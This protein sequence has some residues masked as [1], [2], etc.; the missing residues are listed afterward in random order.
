[1]I[2]RPPRSTLFPYTTL[3]RSVLAVLD[4]TLVPTG[5]QLRAQKG[6]PLGVDIRLEG[7][8][9]A[10]D[11]RVEEL[12][13]LVAAKPAEAPAEVW[14]AREAL[15]VGAEPAVGCRLSVLPTRLGALCARVGREAEH[16]GRPWR[17]VAPAGRPGWLSAGG[18]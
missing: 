18:G 1:M 14:E 10:L 9:A 8:E 17:V 7:E 5:L 11:A 2:R 16:G 3:F 15:W 4:S 6:G 12:R 13:G